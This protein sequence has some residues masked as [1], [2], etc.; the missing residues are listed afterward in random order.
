M[1]KCKRAAAL[2]LTAALL[3]GAAGCGAKQTEPQITAPA[4]PA[5]AAPVRYSAEP[6]FV[7]KTETVY[8]NLDHS[9]KKT[10]L[11]VTDWLHTD[12][13]EVAAQDVSDLENITD[14]KGECAPE[15]NGN[16]LTWHMG[17]TD[18]YYTGTTDKQLPVEFSIEYKLDGKKL[19]AEEIAGRSGKAEITVQMKNVCE[20]DGVF[21]PVVAAGLM[22]LPESD[23]SGIG[24]ENGLSVGDGTKQIIVGLGL[25]GMAESLGLREGAKLGSITV[26]DSFTVTAQTECFALGNLYF[27][28]LPLGSMDLST[29]VPG[30]EAEAAAFFDEVGDVLQ[31]LGSMDIGKLTG[32][33]T[34]E[35]VENLASVLSEAVTAY[36][37]NEALLQVLAKYMTPENIDSIS[38]LLTALQEPETVKMLETLNSPVVKKLLSASPDL[39]ESIEALTPV[40][41]ELQADLQSADVQQALNE[42]PQ[43][44]QTLGKL[45]KAMEDNKE[46]LDAL[47]GVADSG[48]FETL[49][50]LSGESEAQTV[51]GDLT[52]HADTLL[53]KLQAYVA[54]G[55]E[56]GLFTAAAEGTQLN[57]LFIYM[58]PSLQAEAVSAEP[59]TETQEPWYKKIF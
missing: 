44:L 28:V 57:L 48:L 2:V 34:G 46:L 14:I 36:K 12:K 22:I 15:Q 30:S 26:A 27:A 19:S 31:A 42:I 55:R 17:G 33:L 52:D 45:Q 23:F 10:S 16:R 13:G 43:T 3:L 47:R 35:N 37:K 7:R 41:R 59:V 20:Q 32:A 53:P 1:R 29:L 38:C 24:V 51:L 18:L 54:F 40:L 50:G 8:V 11:S 5:S 6:G 25:P 49:A 58:T 56:Y 4:V 9:G 21:L 39:L